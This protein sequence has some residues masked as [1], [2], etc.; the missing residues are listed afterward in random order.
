VPIA[1]F[2]LDNTLLDR[3][4]AFA[5]WARGFCEAWTSDEDALACLVSWDD[6]GMTPREEVFAAVRVILG[7]DVA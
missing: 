2:D 4:A 6:D 7:E 3:A 5:R 1:L